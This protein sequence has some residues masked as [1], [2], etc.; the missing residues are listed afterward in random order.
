VLALRSPS[1]S[2]AQGLASSERAVRPTKKPAHLAVVGAIVTPDSVKQLQADLLADYDALD[3]AVMACNARS[4]LDDQ[5]LLEWAAMQD[6][7]AAFLK[8]EP[9][10]VSTATQMD[11]GQAIQKDLASWHA[12][13]AQKGCTVGPAPTVVDPGIGIPSMVS[14]AIADITSSPLLLVALVLLFMR[15]TRGARRR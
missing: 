12:R 5:T 8:L 10:W 11:Q 9:S 14:K 1:R 15:E 7:V 6:R 13:L 4:L 2:Q 3:A